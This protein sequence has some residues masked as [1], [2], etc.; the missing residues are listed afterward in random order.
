MVKATA[1][2]V[3]TLNG[4]DLEQFHGMVEEVRQRPESGQLGFFEKV[5]WDFGVS[6]DAHTVELRQPGQSMKRKFTLR[7]DHPPE[8]LGANTGPSAA[9]T[10]LM[11]LGA[12]VAGTFVSQATARGIRLDQLEVEVEGQLDLNGFLGLKDV[13]AGFPGINLRIKAKC[14]CD[15]QTLEELA[16]A[17]AKAS[18]VYDSV[19]NPVRINSSVERL[20]V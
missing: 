11:G 10:M 12:C 7:I 13:R 9:E 8:L 19:A 16:R 14:D 2:A 17:T 6:A 15:Q 3:N 1:T 4:F 18:P 5:S 20:Q